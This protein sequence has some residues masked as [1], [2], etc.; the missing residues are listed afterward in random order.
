MPTGA[1]HEI[2][3]FKGQERALRADRIG[4]P[5]LLLSV[6]AAGAP[7]MVVAGVM[8]TAYQVTGVVGQPLL[9]VVLGVVM[10]LFSAGYAELSRHVHNAGALYA[11]IAR[12]LG[13]T[14][15]AGASFVALA[16]YSALQ[17]GIHGIFGFACAALLG[18]LFGST[19]A[20]WVPAVLAVLL[21]GALGARKIGLTAG[22]L[23]A[24][25][26]AEVALLVVLGLAF[27]ARPGPQGLTLHAFDPTTLGGTGLGAALCFA[28]AGF[29]G[30][31][32]APVYAE[33]TSRPRTAVARA[34]FLAVGF[35]ALLFA[36]GSWL[37]GVATGPDH[38]VAAAGEEG[39]GLLF[40]LAE[41]R[42]GGLFTDV[43]RVSFVT[44]SFASMLSFHH[45]VARYAFAMG[46][47]GLLP[48]P[49]G[50]TSKTGGAPALGSLLQTVVSL[51]VV[52]AFAVTDRR[53]AGDPTTPVL[54]LFAWGGSLGALGV[55]ALMATSCAA[56]IAFFVRRGAGRGQAGRLT[57]AA[58]AGLALLVVLIYAVKDFGVLAGSGAGRPLGRW[59]PAVM[60]LAAVAGLVHGRVLRA[61]RP[62]V[63]ARIGLGN[64]A[65]QLDKLNKLNELKKSEKAEKSERTEKSEKATTAEPRLSPGNAVRE[66][67]G[68]AVREGC[69]NDVRE[70]RRP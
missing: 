5:G 4:T 68:D 29:L 46:R 16:A 17:V 25:L 6:L 64:E 34:M 2:S 65:F 45:V 7:L 15:G 48:A 8:A 18:T 23:G 62:W 21:T 3:T 59:L 47:E 31:E 14:V 40:A 51:L 22:V 63:H 42:L 49:F 52:V 12:G 30:F 37:L 61:V 28:V 60:G 53:P 57:A 19:V 13:G 1:P 32:Q 56:V 69:G 36:A 43:L 39:P 58:V 11:G 67:R 50:R 54:R 9:F 33:E 27:A 35:S 38:V 41:P 66:G 55:I 70:E 10:A 44:G 24:L 26:L 20:W